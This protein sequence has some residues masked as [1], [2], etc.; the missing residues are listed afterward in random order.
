MDKLAN[1]STTSGLVA[2]SSKRGVSKSRNAMRLAAMGAAAVLFLGFGQAPIAGAQPTSSQSD[3]NPNLSTQMWTPEREAELLRD[4][5]IAHATTSQPSAGQSLTFD[6]G[7]AIS[8]GMS[9]SFAQ[10]YAKAV[11]HYA[12]GAASAEPQESRMQPA[13]ANGSL[14]CFIAIT[15]LTIGMAAMVAA[16]FA[17]G[18]DV[19][20]AV[21]GYSVSAI[22]AAR[23]C[24]S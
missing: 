15:G 17:T 22:S 2:S 13:G 6:K 1:G 11:A 21:A 3:V 8:E 14:D 16:I 18:G 20:L 10:E 7:A 23:A 5:Q 9:L 24:Y 19:A 4:I 12:E